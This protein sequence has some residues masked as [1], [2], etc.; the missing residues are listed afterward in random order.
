MLDWLASSLDRF[1]SVGQKQAWRFLH[2]SL[3]PGRSHLAQTV[4]VT[5]AH[6]LTSRADVFGQN[7]TRPSRSD[8]GQFSTCW[9]G[10]SSEEW[11]WIG[12]KK[13][14]PTHTTQ[15]DSGHT[16]AIMA[17]T[18]HNQNTSESNLARLLGLSMQKMH[19]SAVEALSRDEPDGR[20]PILQN[21]FFHVH[22]TLAMD[23]PSFSL[24]FYGGLGSTVQACLMWLICTQHPIFHFSQCSV[25]LCFRCFIYLIKKIKKEM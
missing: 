13:S 18:G 7:L 25:S 3:F 11:S 14:D 21:H 6:W 5:L 16:L 19:K 8:P 2:A 20:P 10:P 17:V 1:G 24:D 9:S 22:E 15:P 12:C 23:K 4:T